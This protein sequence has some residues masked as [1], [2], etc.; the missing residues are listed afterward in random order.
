MLGTYLKWTII[1]FSFGLVGVGLDYFFLRRLSSEQ[2]I[3]A[4]VAITLAAMAITFFLD[5]KRNSTKK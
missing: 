1:G 3:W 2:Q 5:K 4:F